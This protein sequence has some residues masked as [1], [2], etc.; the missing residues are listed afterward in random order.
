VLFAVELAKRLDGTGVTSNLLHPGAV[1]TD[2]MRELPWLIRT[3]VNLM[4]IDTV[5]GAQTTIMLASDPDLASVTGKYYDQC[6]PDT[7]ATVADDD[8]L[9]QKLWEVSA[10][11]I[12]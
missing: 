4:F 12:S 6:E 3:A 1:R 7:Y 5:K 8:A 2:I 9:R 10:G 11:A